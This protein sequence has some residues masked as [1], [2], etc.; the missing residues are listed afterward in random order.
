MGVSSKLG[1]F[2]LYTLTYLMTYLCYLFLSFSLYCMLGT[3][4]EMAS[5]VELQ[6]TVLS[7]RYS[8]FPDIIRIVSVETKYCT[9]LNISCSFSFSSTFRVLSRI[10]GLLFGQCTMK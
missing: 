6:Y 7:Q 9:T 8:I 5:T 3:K 4:I 10:F 1:H 2:C